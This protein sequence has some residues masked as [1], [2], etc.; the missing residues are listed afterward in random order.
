MLGENGFEETFGASSPAPY[1]AKTLPEKGE[2]L[3][4]YYAVTKGDLANQIALLSGQGPTPETAANCPNYT[5]VLPGTVSPEGQVEGAGCVYPA[6]TPTLP[7][8]L[9]EKKLSWKAYVED[10]GNGAAAGQATSCRHPLP[11]GPDTSPGPVARRRLL[12][13]AQPVRLFPLA[14][15]RR[16]MRRERRRLRSA[17]GRPENGEEDASTLLHRSQR[18]SRRR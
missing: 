15:R 3:A 17:G 12:D 10:I 16:G 5:D 8:Q 4:N 13:L 6:M 18:L 1:L 14:P 11:G 9:V 7:G 2:L